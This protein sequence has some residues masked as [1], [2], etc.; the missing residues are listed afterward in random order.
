[1]RRTETKLAIPAT[2]QIQRNVCH[3]ILVSYG[4]RAKKRGRTVEHGWTLRQT[5]CH[6]F[7]RPGFPNM[8]DRVRPFD[9]QVALT[10]WSIVFPP[11]PFDFPAFPATPSGVTD[12]H[13]PVHEFCSFANTPKDVGCDG[14]LVPKHISGGV[15]RQHPTETTETTSGRLE[16]AS[17]PPGLRPP[18]AAPGQPVSATRETAHQDSSSNSA[19]ASRVARPRAAPPRF[20]LRPTLTSGLTTASNPDSTGREARGQR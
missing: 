14:N 1:M 8:C 2:R 18:C 16:D 3:D 11:R 17:R 12:A 7:F 10:P 19:S 15:F 20:G 13:V 6:A 4:V 5:F 9:R